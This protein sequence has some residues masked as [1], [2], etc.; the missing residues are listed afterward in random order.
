MFSSLF[1]T[2]LYQPIFNAFIGLYNIVPGHDV[3]VVILIITLI[4]RLVLY[5][6]TNSSIKAQ[7]SM[8]E[9]QP[10]MDLLKKQFGKDQ[11][12]L[13][14]ATMKLYKEHKVNPLTSCLPM[15]VQLPVLIA[16]YL[17]LQDGL[18]G[19]NL[20]QNLYSF[21]HN[22]EKIGQI[23]LGIFDLAKPSIVLAF[24]AGAAQFLQAK[25]MVRKK[26]PKV[27]GEGAKDEDMMAMM[28]KQM[29]YL[30]PA[31]TFLIGMRLPAGLTL[32]WF[33]S[34]ILMVGQQ[35]ILFRQHP[36]AAEAAVVVNSVP[37]A[38]IS[39]TVEEVKTI[40]TK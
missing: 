28:N 23:S 40:E 3:G 15:L 12:G 33:L 5:P 31:M 26:S 4:I 20:A 39:G 9:L 25:G 36:T 30:M 14:Q 32:Y 7:K 24:L 10:R 11:Q 21:V 16:L 13:A 27:A 38:T 37:G 18:A 2:V 34:T 22:P 8:Q 35:F 6:L 1:H 29:L 17:V 19:Q